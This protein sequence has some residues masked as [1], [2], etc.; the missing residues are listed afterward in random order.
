MPAAKAVAAFVNELAINR[1][2]LRLIQHQSALTRYLAHLV[3]TIYET[4]FPAAV[5]VQPFSRYLFFLR[6]RSLY[7]ARLPGR[8]TR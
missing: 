3:N 7:E 8:Q 5:P 2:G 6:G 1:A 4:I